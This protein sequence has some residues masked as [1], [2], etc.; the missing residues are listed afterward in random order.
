MHLRGKPSGATVVC[1]RHRFLD[2][3]PCTAG[4]SRAFWLLQY[5]ERM[6]SYDHCDPHAPGGVLFSSRAVR[7][8]TPL[9]SKRA[10]TGLISPI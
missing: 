10:H 9:P 2:N 7:D 1:S 3:G 5:G 6:I 4:R 8:G